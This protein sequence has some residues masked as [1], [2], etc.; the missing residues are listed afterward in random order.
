MGAPV[1]AEKTRYGGFEHGSE[2][3]RNASLQKAAK[4]EGVDGYETG[5][6]VVNKSGRRKSRNNQDWWR[7]EWRGWMAKEE[8]VVPDA[9]CT[10]RRS[11]E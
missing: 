10:I 9:G 8:G 6:P 4:R 2:G 11:V 3:R 7:A 5:I 1:L